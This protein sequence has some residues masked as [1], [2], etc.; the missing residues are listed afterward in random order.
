MINQELGELTR[1]YSNVDLPVEVDAT[2]DS[3]L[4]FEQQILKFGAAARRA[5]HMPALQ[6]YLSENAARAVSGDLS[7][8]ALTEFFWFL[9]SQKDWP[10]IRSTAEG[11]RGRLRHLP[12]H[13]ADLIFL[14]FYRSQRDR[15]M[16]GKERDGF[17]IDAKET[18]AFLRAGWPGA[19]RHL[20]A[21]E[22]MSAHAT[23]NAVHARSS[24][25]SV[26]DLKF[27]EPFAGI[28]SVLVETD[29][30]GTIVPEHDIEV[31]PSAAEHVTL[32][33]LD[34]T[35]FEKY[36]LL[37]ARRYAQ[38]N[39]T[40]G[41]HFHCVGFDSREAI[42]SWGVPVSFGFT[43]DHTDLSGLEVRQKRGYYASARYIHLARY[44]QLYRSVFVGDVDG[45]VARDLRQME[46][47][48]AHLDVLLSTKVLD[49]ARTLNRLPWESVTACSFM[50]RQTPGALRFANRI[51][52][53][54]QRIVENARSTGRPIWYADQTALFYCWLDS[55]HDVAFGTFAKPAFV[56]RGS[57]QLF[58]GEKERLDF[59]A[60][61]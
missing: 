14:A 43:I 9:F 53:Y 39:P 25:V 21:F 37:V 40:N 6:R 27:I 22:A 32:L 60:N 20:A 29:Y 13:V 23:G 46:S 33:S 42:S 10:R 36:A 28:S 50:A 1:C 5:V 61:P 19:E 31:S 51:G 47:E 35:Y 58:Q 49:K 41:L 54:L 55:E 56:Q 45:H 11:L 44:L 52:A 15:L 26:G 16:A 38:T 8:E 30:A 17:A 4:S 2:L 12:L 57:W 7:D 24:F 59:L 18:T 48:H 3:A 34:R